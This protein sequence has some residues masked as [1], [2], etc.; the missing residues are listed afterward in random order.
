VSMNPTNFSLV[1]QVVLSKTKIP[2]HDW[3]PNE[4]ERKR[5]STMSVQTVAAKLEELQQLLQPPSVNLLMTKVPASTLARPPIRVRDQVLAVADMLGQA[6]ELDA[7]KVLALT[8]RTMGKPDEHFQER[9]DAL[10]TIGDLGLAQRTVISRPKVLEQ[11]PQA[12]QLKISLIRQAVQAGGSEEF[13][14]DLE[15]MSA[16]QLG[17]AL[18]RG[19]PGVLRLK[20]LAEKRY[21]VDRYT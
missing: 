17:Y 2:E 6:T 15:R 9:I 21:N 12:I 1:K 20:Y 16:T 18:T 13:R 19:V 4:D 10:A 11:T 14:R 8:R 7:A 5:L 3:D